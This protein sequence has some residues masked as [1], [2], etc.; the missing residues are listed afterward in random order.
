MSIS[1]G[2]N[3]DV[4]IDKAEFGDKKDSL[5]LTFKQKAEK[6]LTM[7]EKLQADEHIE[8]TTGKEIRLFAPLVNKDDDK[9]EEKKVDLAFTD[10]N[11]TKGQLLHILE[12][13]MTKKD[14][15]L[16]DIYLGIGMSE[17]N[18]REKML[19]QDALKLIFQN[20]TNSFLAKIKPWVS[21]KDPTFRL[22][23]VRQSK[24]KHYPTLRKRFLTESP[25]W[26]PMFI[27]KTDS[28]VAFTP[29]EI[30]EGLTSAEV[31]QKDQADKTAAAPQKTAEEIFK[32]SGMT[33]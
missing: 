27:P 10:I 15:V 16:G 12:G 33:F 30:R 5:I 25:F 29:Y 22:L 11:N 18:F 19:N 1:I 31:I 13:Y 23:L 4:Y 8:M 24:D 28:K 21:V 9:T 26:E 14:A 7:Y 17:E 20:M 6:E 2:I 32:G 3:E